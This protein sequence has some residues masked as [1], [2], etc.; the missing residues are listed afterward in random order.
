M[1]E[2][3]RIFVGAD[4]S[5]LAS[6]PVLEYTIRKHTD[7]PVQVVPLVDMDLP[8]PKNP[9]NWPRTNFSFCRFAIPMLCRYEGSAL[10]LDADMMVF[11]DIGEIWRIAGQTG[12]AITIQQ[13]IEAGPDAPAKVGAPKT[14]KRQCA[15]MHLKCDRLMWDPY[16]IIA[17]LD[18]RYDYYDLMER[19][20]IESDDNISATL[21][22]SWNSL[23]KYEN[24]VT[25][26]LHF[27]DMYTQPWVSSENPLGYLWVNVLREMLQSGV[28]DMSFIQTEIR[29]GYFR[30]SLVFELGEP[31]QNA[32]CETL[33]KRC[34]EIDKK[35]DF[36]KHREVY[37]RKLK[38]KKAMVKV[39]IGDSTG[40]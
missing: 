10:Y 3:L 30:P 20:C 21:P 29:L 39:K 11:Y 4:R 15:V 31:Q 34:A 38:M 9:A 40:Q 27:T 17:G 25:R 33:S 16:E 26:L 23:E 12:R 32:F 5:Q 6:V 19:L 36:V 14:R 8:Y 1:Q 22:F 35:A 2:P 13:D 7:H 18:S 37:E 28:V 24:G